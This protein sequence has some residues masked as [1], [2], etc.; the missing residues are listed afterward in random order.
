MTNPLFTDEK[1][2]I[3]PIWNIL[4][5]SD[6]ASDTK[7]IEIEDNL[8]INDKIFRLEINLP[9]EITVYNGIQWFSSSIIVV[10]F[11]LR[12]DNAPLN[13]LK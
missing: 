9:K 13:Q 12:N 7:S 10:Y 1:A 6:E 5:V 3:Q 4:N 11:I 2:W 8:N